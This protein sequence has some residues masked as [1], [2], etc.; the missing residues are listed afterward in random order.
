MHNVL[1]PAHKIRGLRVHAK[2]RLHC[3]PGTRPIQ[4]AL[5]REELAGV[6]RSYV[7]HLFPALIPRPVDGPCS[8]GCSPFFGPPEMGVSTANCNT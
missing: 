3:G 7:P 5:P 2:P 6:E 8:V 1:A 4:T